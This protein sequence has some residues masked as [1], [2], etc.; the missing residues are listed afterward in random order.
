VVVRLTL[1]LPHDLYHVVV[2]DPF[3]AGMEA[4]DPNLKTTQLGEGG[5]PQA[6]QVLSQ[7][8]P[9]DPYS[10]GWGWWNFHPAQLFD[11]RIAWTADYLPAGTYQL[12]Y[13]LLAFQ[14]GEYRVLPARAWQFYFPDVQANSTGEVFEVK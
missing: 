7:F 9:A 6:E 14:P 2:E 13:T 12:S 3:P 10:A 5:E 4:Q 1:I 8:D 11:D